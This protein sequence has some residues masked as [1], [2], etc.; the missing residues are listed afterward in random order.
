[1]EIL[2][3]K[4]LNTCRKPKQAQNIATKIGVL[5]VSVGA[6]QVNRPLQALCFS[7]K[8]G[9]FKGQCGPGQRIDLP[10]AA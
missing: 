8:F 2:P 6:V 10:L 7:V 3:T 1:M 9:F 4:E 5:T